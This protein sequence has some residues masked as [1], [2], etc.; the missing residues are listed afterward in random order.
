MTT[1]VLNQ[2]RMSSAT[3]VAAPLLKRIW[4]GL[5][6]AGARRAAAELRRQALM[7]SD[8][9]PATAAQMRRA[10]ATIEADL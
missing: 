6:T 5:M 7:R 3:P 8:S 4:T 9:S 1:T 2:P 10:A